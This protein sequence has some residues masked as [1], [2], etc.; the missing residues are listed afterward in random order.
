MAMKVAPLSADLLLKIALVAGGIV[1]AVYLVRRSGAA[2]T[3][4]VGAVVHELGE[5][6]DSVIVGVNPAN[7]SNWVNQA[8]TSA[9][10]AVVSA[11]GPGRNADGSWSLGGW[12]Y[13]VTHADP[14][15]QMIYLP[16]A[17]PAA[18]PD[19][20]ADPTRAAFG[21]FPQLS[22]GSAAQVQSDLLTIA[23][24]GRVVGGL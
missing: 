20:G 5:V 16:S 18:V 24:R 21:F 22:M 19:Y 14:V 10:S 17:P 12:L 7:P 23:E 8:V 6:A 15:G 1:L 9:G 3:G 13:D 4:A 2:V 11:T